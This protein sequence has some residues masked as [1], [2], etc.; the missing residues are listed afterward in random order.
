MTGENKPEQMMK[1]ART[2]DNLEWL[3]E[4]KAVHDVVTIS[5]KARR[6]M[7][8]KRLIRSGLALIRRSQGAGPHPQTSGHR[9]HPH[10]YAHLRSKSGGFA[11]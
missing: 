7:L 3:E 1:A 2:K 4:V 9:R 8:A 10:T 11:N 6:I 5:G